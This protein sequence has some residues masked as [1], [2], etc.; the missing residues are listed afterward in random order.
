MEEDVKKEEGQ[1]EKASEEQPLEKPLDRMT[2]KELREI[3]MEMPEIVGSHAMKKEELLAAIKKVRGIEDEGPPKK[4]TKTEPKVVLSAAE[5]KGRISRLKEEKQ[6]AREA[7]ER[8]KV[9]ILRRRINRA[10]KLTRKAG[11]D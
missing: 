9:E 6:R 3:A 4:R 1:E 8:K 2:A 10:K 7:K 5:L 11:R